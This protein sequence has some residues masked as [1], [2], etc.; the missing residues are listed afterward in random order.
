VTSYDVNSTQ[1]HVNGEN[2]VFLSPG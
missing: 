1:P 2:R